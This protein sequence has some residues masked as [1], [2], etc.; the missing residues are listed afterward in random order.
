MS[1]T[2]QPPGDALP[3]GMLSI[4]ALS[5]ATGVPVETLRTWERRYGFPIPQRTSAGHRVY[6]ISALEPIKSI[7][8]EIGRASW[9]ERV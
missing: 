4:S 3:L 5:Q 9:R 1:K 8:Q 6:P 2:S 7:A